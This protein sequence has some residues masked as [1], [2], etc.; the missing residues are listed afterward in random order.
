MIEKMK[1]VHIVSTA[2]EKDA[3]LERLRELGVVH[4]SEKADADRQ[5]LERFAALS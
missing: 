3:L 5:Y 1:V 2:P 4:F